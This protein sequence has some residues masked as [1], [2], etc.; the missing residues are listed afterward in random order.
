[1]CHVY[2]LKDKKK[3]TTGKSSR[4]YKFSQSLKK[5]TK[6][7]LKDENFAPVVINGKDLPVCDSVKILD[8]GISAILN[9]N[10]DTCE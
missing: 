2:V 5:K 8:I 10:D 6:L 4:T 3:S 7:K 1:M 9:W